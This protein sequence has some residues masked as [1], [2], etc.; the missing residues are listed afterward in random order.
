MLNATIEIVASEA[1]DQYVKP[2]KV[3]ALVMLGDPFALGDGNGPDSPKPSWTVMISLDEAKLLGLNI[4]PGASILP[5]GDRPK[6]FIDSVH[7][8]SKCLWLDCH[9]IK[10]AV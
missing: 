4:I 7:E 5:D 1:R 10:G 3:E 2:I 9:S 6:L 8:N